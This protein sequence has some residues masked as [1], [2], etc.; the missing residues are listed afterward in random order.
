MTQETVAKLV[1]ELVKNSERV[2]ALSGTS[3][4]LQAVKNVFANFS[5][6]NVCLAT[7]T[8]PKANYWF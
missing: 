3:K 7:S 2:T 8:G 5:T 1:R 4:E 6:Q